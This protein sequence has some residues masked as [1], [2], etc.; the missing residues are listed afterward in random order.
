MGICKVWIV[1]DSVTVSGDSLS[2]TAAILQQDAEIK[3]RQ[4]VVGSLI[5]GGAIVSFR[6][7]EVAGLMIEPTE[8]EVGLS[9]GRVKQ[10]SLVIGSAGFL[11]RVFL[12]R[13][14]VV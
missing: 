9:Q 11:G 7:I 3:V 14:S 6:L 13:K 12:D 8:V 5:N 1:I 2:A 10:Q 4:S